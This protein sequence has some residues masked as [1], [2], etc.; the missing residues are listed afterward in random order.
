VSS[1]DG[2]LWKYYDG[3][4]T[5]SGIYK[6]GFLGA[7]ALATARWL[8]G[9][10]EGSIV[11]CSESIDCRIGSYNTD[12]RTWYDYNSAGLFC[13]VLFNGSD[14]ITAIEYGEGT[15][16]IGSYGSKVSSYNV[17]G[18]KK[19][20]GTG[21]G[22][23]PYS[24]YLLGCKIGIIRYY[25]NSFVFCSQ[26]DLYGRICSWTNDSGWREYNGSGTGTGVYGNFVPFFRVQY[27]IETPYGTYYG[28]YKA[29]GPFRAGCVN[30]ANREVERQ[31][32]FA[33]VGGVSSASNQV[34]F[35]AKSL[36]YLYLYKYENGNTY[37]CNIVGNEDKKSICDSN[38]WVISRLN[39]MSDSISIMSNS[40]RYGVPQFKNGVTRHILTMPFWTSGFFIKAY[41]FV[42]YINFNSFTDTEA[43]ENVGPPLVDLTVNFGTKCAF[44]YGEGYF[45]TQA[46]PSGK[47]HAIIPDYNV[48]PKT[49]LNYRQQ[50]TQTFADGYGKL[51]NLLGEPPSEPFE[52]RVLM[53]N[54]F[55]A[56][57]SVG[58][59]DGGG[60]D[61]LGVLLTNVGE[62]DDTYQPQ[63]LGANILYKCN[64]IFNIIR[65]ST[66]PPRFQKISEK[67]FKINT[68]SPFNIIDTESKTLELGSIDYNGRMIFNS[69][70]T[71]STTS[72]KT[73]STIIGKHSASIDTGE[74]LVQIPSMTSANWEI[75]GVRIPY[76]TSILQGYT[77]D[78]FY[79][80]TSTI[81]QASTIN[82]GDELI[83]GEKI[84]T[85]Y[86]PDTRIPPA[87]GYEY[88]GGGLKVQSK[89]IFLQDA[90][91]GYNVGSEV[92]GTFTIFKL[93]GQTYIFDGNSI[94]IADILNNSFNSKLFIAPA[95]GMAYIAS[96]PTAIFFLS[97]FDNAL[98]T[99]DGGRTLSKIKR[100]SQKSPIVKGVFSVIENALMLETSTSFIWNRDSIFTENL[101]A[102]TQ[103]S[104]KLYDTADGVIIGNNI[105][106]W[107]YSYNS[108]SSVI[109][110]RVK[111]PYM[112]LDANI[113]SITQEI[114]CTLYSRTIQ[115]VD[116]TLTL[117]GF[118]GSTNF[119]QT[120]VY[121]L[122]ASDFNNSGYARIRLQPSYPK[123]LGVALTFSTPQKVVLSDITVLFA[124][125]VNET[126]KSIRSK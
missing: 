43:F 85:L 9:A 106:K 7:K 54:G 50:N 100:L 61:C 36:N 126:I 81:Y 83:V 28:G 59:I 68:I 34:L 124:D 10:Y 91:D 77:V 4:G 35:G 40:A 21:T 104:L 78:T 31:T 116:V 29:G 55:M 52:V 64:G 17:N 112:G 102:A 14:Y 80:V 94:F 96:S 32:L 47:Y 75:F 111:T 57:L 86:V 30:Y 66:T 122:K 99:F 97:S 117:S 88:Q 2:S 119:E 71:A 67:L 103:T 25:K 20:D 107:Q 37:F 39:D 73:V 87:I 63:V 101:K 46:T 72:G 76:S 44:G 82:N 53:V 48:F 8:D 12:T 120:R 98:Y 19:H 18:W 42:G 92:Q 51:S 11:F 33:T 26:D 109:P 65:L 105:S 58:I 114:I 118:N 22:T 41:S 95:R 62:F 38:S 113:K 16:V 110:L 6:D 93:F 69:I 70:A 13:G 121:N 123:A 108:G 27:F 56:G 115:P 15:L 45:G 89:T 3:T 74:K 90:Y 1:F 84:N 5:G 49:L 60:E 24:T 125:D 79:G 23:G